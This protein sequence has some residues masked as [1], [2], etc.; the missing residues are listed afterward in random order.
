MAVKWQART[1]VFLSLVFNA[2]AITR[3]IPVGQETLFGF[4][5]STT[6]TS[7]ASSYTGAAAYDPRTLIPPT[8]PTD[9][10][11]NT[12]IAVQLVNGDIP[13]LSIRHT[14]AFIG[15]SIELSVSNHICEF[16]LGLLL[17]SRSYSIV[18]SGSQRVRPV[19]RSFSITHLDSRNA[20]RQYLFPSSICWLT[21][22]NVLA[23]LPSAL[24]ATL[25]KPP[26]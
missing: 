13:N 1:L 11:V 5:P 6:D 22:K 7:L 16:S 26:S 10:A 2:L 12:N 24:V 8:P 20:G 15:F 23:E 14:G 9:P 4:K 3:Y 19:P 25:R 21:S 18:S 17:Q